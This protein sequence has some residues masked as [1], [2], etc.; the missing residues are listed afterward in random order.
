[1]S[2]ELS[3]EHRQ[4]LVKAA[5][6]EVLCLGGGVIGY[7]VTGNWVFLVGGALLGAGFILPI[8]ITIMKARK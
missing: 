2:R 7:L 5:L 1:M 6:L 4:E 8:L 3:P